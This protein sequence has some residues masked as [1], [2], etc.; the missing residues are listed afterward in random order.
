MI[1]PDQCVYFLLF[2][3]NDLAQLLLLLL[4]IGGMLFHGFS[5]ALDQLVEGQLVLLEL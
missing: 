5:Y 4:L 1:V 3:C 2:V